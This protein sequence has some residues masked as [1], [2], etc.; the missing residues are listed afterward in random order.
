MLIEVPAT[1][2][3]EFL[4]GLGEYAVLK[5]QE[6]WRHFESGGDLDLLVE[7]LEAAER[8]LLRHLGMPTRR[9]VRSYVS[10]YHY[11]WGQIDLLAQF[12]WHGAV[13]LRKENV[14]AGLGTSVMGFSAPRPAHEAVICWLTSLLWGGFFKERYREKILAACGSDAAALKE[15]LVQAA[16]PVCGGRLFDAVQSGQPELTVTAVQS[17][18]RSVWWRAFRLDLRGTVSRWVAFWLTEMRLRMVRQVPWICILGPDGSGKSTVIEHLARRLTRR[19]EVCGVDLY[20]W[21]PEVVRPTGG[22]PVTNPHA[23]PPHSR[24]KSLLKLAF[25]ACDWSLWYWMRLVHRQAK[26]YLS[27]FDRG[28][29]DILV[30]PHRYRYGGPLWL[31]RLVGFCL[32]APDTTIVLDANSEVLRSRKQE[33]APEECARQRQA[34]LD[35]A[36]HTPSSHVVDASQPIEAVVD[37]VER[38]VRAGMASVGLRGLETS[39]S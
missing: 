28:Y 9:L 16:G 35:L 10:N 29:A 4:H 6:V 8:R 26:G 20:H 34:Y 15:A 2:L 3:D 23:S 18:R 13:F 33:V 19:R 14:F 22:E 1:R 36:K 30:D 38:I 39:V 31:A 11:P 32:P 24:L 21:R 7:D 27:V 17:I 37:E 12:E 5:N 25:L